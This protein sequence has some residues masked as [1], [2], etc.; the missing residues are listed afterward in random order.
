MFPGGYSVVDAGEAALI[1]G[2]IFYA[3]VRYTDKEDKWM[4]G[5]EC[6]KND[7][8]WTDQLCR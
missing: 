3:F 6:G 7:S 1:N 4:R 2:L 5:V 8:G